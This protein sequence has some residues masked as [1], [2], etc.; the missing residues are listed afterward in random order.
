MQCVAETRF[1]CYWLRLIHLASRQFPPP[2]QTLR[3]IPLE[4]VMLGMRPA[5]GLRS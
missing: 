3:A 2:Q 1:D 5:L 4:S